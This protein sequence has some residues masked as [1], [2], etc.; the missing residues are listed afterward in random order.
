M[1]YTD[2]DNL[3]PAIGY[4]VNRKYTPNWKIEKSLIDFHDLTYVYAGLAT[5]FVNEVKYTVERG[6]IVYIPAGSVR[7]AYTYPENPI[8][9]YSINFKW[10]LPENNSVNLPFPVISK[11]GI[12]NEIIDLYKDFNNV[13]IEKN[14]GYMMKARAIFMLILHKLLCLT[15]YKNTALTEDYRIKKIKDY[16]MIH[17]NEKIEI[18]QLAM[19]LGLT[20]VY[21]GTLFKRNNDC[22]IKQY[23]TRIRINNAENLLSTGEYTVGEVAQ[24]CGFE[25][26]FYFSKVFKK[27][28]GYPPSNAL[29]I[30]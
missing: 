4:F 8:Q 17:Y 21:L 2:F 26:I 7:Q 30:K 20:P 9:C 22:S 14:P 23:I 3:I 1:T 5:Y 18:K 27:Y 15:Y 16:I 25:D 6:D 24:Q 28:K 29:K 19:L 10:Y 13:W 12:F 11:L